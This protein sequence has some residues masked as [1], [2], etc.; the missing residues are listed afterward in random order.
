MRHV[1]L[2]LLPALG[3]F[4][5]GALGPRL[6]ALRAGTSTLA[7][8]AALARWGIPASRT[9]GSGLPLLAPSVP[10]RSAPASRTFGSGLLRPSLG[11][12]HPPTILDVPLRWN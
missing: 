2:L 12:V 6:T 11:S 8:L 1:T 10:G 5:A 9:F 4:G 3:A 7:S